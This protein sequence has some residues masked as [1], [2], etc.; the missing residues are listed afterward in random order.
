[1]CTD[2]SA[3]TPPVCSSKTPSMAYKITGLLGKKYIGL[4]TDHSK[5]IQLCNQS[6]SKNNVKTKNISPTK[7]Q[8]TQPFVSYIPTL[9]P[10]ASF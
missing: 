9:N 5:P 8:L 3:V 7:S 1:M 10:G 2:V 4:G 6:T